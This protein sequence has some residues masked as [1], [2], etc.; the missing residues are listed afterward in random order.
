[1]AIT[2]VAYNFALVGLVL[3]LGSVAAMWLG[4]YR[5][6]RW[7]YSLFAVAT[8]LNTLPM[9]V[10]GRL[11]ESAEMTVA[12]CGAVL[13]VVAAVALVRGALKFSR[14]VPNRHS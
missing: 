8:T 9:L 12:V 11:S 14:M 3:V 1:M 10:P 6:M 7:S 2:M 4:G 5:E 13:S